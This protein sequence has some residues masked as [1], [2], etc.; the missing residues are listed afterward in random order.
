MLH[1]FSRGNVCS[2]CSHVRGDPK[3]THCHCKHAAHGMGGSV[4]DCPCCGTHPTDSCG[5]GCYPGFSKHPN[6]LGML[7]EDGIFTVGQLREAL[8]KSK[9]PIHTVIQL[10]HNEDVI[11]A[12][13]YR[14]DRPHKQCTCN[15][16]RADLASE[17]G[18]L[19]VW[20][21]DRK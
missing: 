10:D 17:L 11:N 7:L 12:K 6:N 13:V 2:N 1:D 4:D 5:N 19:P 9:L 14:K 3:D 21:K 16:C 18:G 15:K 20:H 8:K